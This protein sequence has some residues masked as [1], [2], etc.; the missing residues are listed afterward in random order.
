VADG[1]DCGNGRDTVDADLKDRVQADCE[2]VDRRPV[3]ETPNVIL[4]GK[5]LRV[6]RRT[7][8]V[9]VRMRCPRGVKRLG[10][11]G[12]LQLKLDR[13][14]GSSRSRKVRYRIKAGKRK[15]VTLKLTR[16]DVRSIRRR[17]RKA[18]GILTSVEKGRKGRKTTIRNPRLRLR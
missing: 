10:C 18:R 3:G 2:D 1:V 17:G 5:A 8:K 16:R 7:G 13:R 11:K 14:A 9:K 4:P 15:T 6:S 12:K